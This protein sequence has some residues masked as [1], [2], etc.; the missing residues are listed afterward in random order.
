MRTVL[1]RSWLRARLRR[2][3]ARPVRNRRVR[4][5]RGTH[6]R[7][8]AA[9]RHRLSRTD[10]RLPADYRARGA[11]MSVAGRTILYTG[12]AGGLGLRATLALLVKGARVVAEIGR[13]H[14]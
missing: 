2:G 1:A 4:R 14:V 12:A 13:A 6:P 9:A 11:G 5:L 10:R 7:D 8:R 3:A